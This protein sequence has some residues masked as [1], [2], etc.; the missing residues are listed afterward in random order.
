VGCFGPGSVG[1]SGL[2]AGDFAPDL[3]VF[4][5]YASSPADLQGFDACSSVLL[6]GGSAI[7]VGP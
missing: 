6:T 5:A 7:G 4:E 2:G 3:L 1:E